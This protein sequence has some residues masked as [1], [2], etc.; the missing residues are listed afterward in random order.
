M[1]LW[2]LAQAKRAHNAF[3]GEGAAR[4]GGRWNPKG[5]R[6]VYTSE[7]SSLTVLEVLVH[8]EKHHFFGARYVFFAVDVPERVKVDTVDPADL[9]DD[10]RRTPAPIALHETG[11]AWIERGESALLRVPSALTPGEHNVLLNP[12]HPD[13]TALKIHDR[14]PYQFDGRL[15]KR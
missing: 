5:V 3:D 12:L 6:C 14:M 2:R 9:P 7:S 10:W 4:W 1:R 13:F 11:K 15:W 8:M